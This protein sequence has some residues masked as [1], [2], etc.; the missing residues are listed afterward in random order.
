M[1][2]TV[3]GILE[4][5]NFGVSEEKFCFTNNPVLWQNLYHVCSIFVS[6]PQDWGCYFLHFSHE[7]QGS[8]RL[9]GVFKVIA[10]P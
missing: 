6:A 7:S 9:K 1:H 3:D 4:P 10:S 2:L 8:W 5:E